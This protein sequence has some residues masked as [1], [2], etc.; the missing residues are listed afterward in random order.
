MGIV[1]W[2]RRILARWD[3]VLAL[4]DSPSLPEIEVPEGRR[5]YEIRTFLLTLEQPNEDAKKYLKTHLERIVRTLSLV[6]EPRS[7]RRVLE[8]GAYMQMTPAL[9]CL[10]GYE[11]RAAYFGT[12]G[13]A[14]TKVARI[15]GREVFRCEIDLFDAEK[16]RFPYL[17]QHFDTVLACEIIEHLLHDPMHMLLEIR[18]V[19]IDKGTL[20]LTTPNISSFASVGRLLRA[21]GHPQICSKYANPERDTGRSEVPHVREWTPRELREA[22]QAAG[23]EVGYLFTETIANYNEERWVRQFLQRNGYPQTLRGEQIYCIATK[24]PAAPVIRYPDFL[25]ER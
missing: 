23:F 11:V 16:D 21:S 25:Y 18:R 12:P 6:P 1:G 13:I 22:L 24:N 8:L 19:L 5:Q 17:E 4:W 15:G 10:L 9:G 14:E 2:T 3:G 20:I 7:T